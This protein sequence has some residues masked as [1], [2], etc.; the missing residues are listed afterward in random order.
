MDAQHRK[1]R[2]PAR[3]DRQRIADLEQRVD[4]LER[5]LKRT[6]AEVA[7]LKALVGGIDGKEHAEATARMFSKVSKAFFAEEGG[8]VPRVE[9]LEHLH[10][11]HGHPP[12]PPPPPSPPSPR[13]R[14]SPA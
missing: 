6:V 4:E 14:P 13:P 5:T 10:R 1:R 7:N 8:L 11:G 9:A 2:V 12:P 3:S